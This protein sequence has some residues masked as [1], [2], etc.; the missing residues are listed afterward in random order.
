M[1]GWKKYL[2]NQ[3]GF[4]MVEMM[5]VL[6]IIAIL[7]GGGVYFY[8]GYIENARVTKAKAQITTMQAA[9]DAYYAEN[10]EYPD[11]ADEL[12]NAGLVTS[13]SQA[14]FTLDAKDPWGKEYEYD[15]AETDDKYVV[16]SGHDAV[17]K[18]D[19]TYVVGRG[20]NGTSTPPGL[21]KPETPPPAP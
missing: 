14:P 2:R 12:L 8:R 17:Q 18:A 21:E 3:H 5:V 4:T 1:S 19:D 16:Y 20:E 13:D 9:L 15:V 10:S 6:I 11:T 7:I